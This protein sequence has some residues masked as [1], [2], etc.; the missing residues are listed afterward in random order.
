MN[1]TKK[2]MTAV[3]ASLLL[4]STISTIGAM[5]S[6]QAQTAPETDESWKT[7]PQVEKAAGTILDWLKG[8]TLSEAKTADEIS[9]KFPDLGS[10]LVENALKRLIWQG[11]IKRT[12]DGSVDNPYKYFEH[13]SGGGGG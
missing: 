4:S 11:D 3:T 2:L 10:T 13:R 5:V 8:T 12:G 7:N 9:K 1:R 6:T